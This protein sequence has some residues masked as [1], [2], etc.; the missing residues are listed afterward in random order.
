MHPARFAE[1]TPDK[2]ALI[3]AET[4]E[5]LTYR[6][7]NERS[8]QGAQLFRKLGLNCGDVV[9][10]FMENNL[11]FLEICWA[12]QR[13]GL[14]YTCISSRLTAGEVAYIVRDSDAKLLLATPGVAKAA[15][16][17]ALLAG[18]KRF[19][20]GG[21]IEGFEPYEAAAAAMPATPISDESAGAD[22]L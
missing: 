6:Q 16:A 4:G 15:S 10:I 19:S 14:Y 8:N 11:R 17:A 18:V 12:A 2:P 3:M 1:T 13:A 7:L 22:M 9:A 21:A 20:V 5:T